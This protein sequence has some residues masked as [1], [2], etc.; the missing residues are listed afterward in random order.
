MVYAKISVSSCALIGR[1]C[2]QNEC[3]DSSH[4]DVGLIRINEFAN[5]LIT[6]LVRSHSPGTFLEI[7]NVDA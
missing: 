3:L 4:R 5:A 2:P 1:H 7:S 6:Y